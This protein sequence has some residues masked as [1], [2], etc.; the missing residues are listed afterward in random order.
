MEAVA[1]QVVFGMLHVTTRLNVSPKPPCNSSH[2]LMESEVLKPVTH[3]THHAYHVGGG[4]GRKTESL[5][6]SAGLPY[7]N[8]CI[9]NVSPC[10]ISL[11]IRTLVAAV[12]RAYDGV[13]LGDTAAECGRAA[14]L[15]AGERKDDVTCD[16][17]AAPPSPAA[18]CL[19]GLGPAA[20]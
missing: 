8:P 20:R 1:K 4:R 12:G 3:K 7:P 2:I 18:A 13:L 5:S 14:G 10:A 16:E 15:V 17:A 11:P 19:T 6:W 9:R